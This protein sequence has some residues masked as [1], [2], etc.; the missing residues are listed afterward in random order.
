M[1]V[2]RSGED[3]IT[4]LNNFLVPNRLDGALQRAPFND[5][6]LRRVAIISRLDPV[7]SI[8]SLL[9]AFDLARSLRSIEFK[10]FGSVSEEA[11]LRKKTLRSN[12]TLHIHGFRS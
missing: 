9:D 3:R 11:V 1:A 2:H 7:K 8:D 12:C 6:G 4:A 5:R 10:V